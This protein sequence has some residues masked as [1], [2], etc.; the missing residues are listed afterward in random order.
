MTVILAG[1]GHCHE[2]DIDKTDHSGI[3]QKLRVRQIRINGGSDQGM[4]QNSNVGHLTVR[5]TWFVTDPYMISRKPPLP[6]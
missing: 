5:M 1:S 6:G 4:I 3:L 2:E